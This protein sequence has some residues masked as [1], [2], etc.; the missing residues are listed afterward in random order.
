MSSHEGI[1]SSKPTRMRGHGRET[2][3]IVGIIAVLVGALVAII[4][5]P[6]PFLFY[7]TSVVAPIIFVNYRVGVW[8]LVFLLPFDQ[9]QLIPHDVLGITGFNPVNSL[10]MFTLLSLLVSFLAGREVIQLVHLPRPFLAYVGVI[11][12]G[13]YVGAGSVEHSI[14]IPDANTGV[15]TEPTVTRYI[16]DHF[17]KPMIILIV[18]W[19][20]AT[21][22]R[23]GNGRPL[24]WALAAAFVIFSL[25]IAHYFVING[26]ST[27]RPGHTR[28]FLYWTGMHANEIGL[29]A[30]LGVAI[31]LCAAGATRGALPRLILFACAAAAGMTAVLTFSRGAF[32]GLSLILGYYLLSLRRI[33]QFLLAFS[34]ILGAGSLLP[35]NALVERATTGFQGADTEVITAGRL[36]Y[37]WRPLLPTFW[38]APIIG[39]GLGSTAWASPNLRGEMLPVGHPH[40]AYLGVLLDLGLVGIAVVGAFFWSA[41]RT[42]RRLSQDHVDSQ[43][44]GVFEGGLVSLMC[45]AIQGLT[46]DQF[47]PTYSQVALW[48]CYGLALGHIQSMHSKER[49]SARSRTLVSRSPLGTRTTIT[50]V[51]TR[52]FAGSPN[53]PA[54]TALRPGPSPR[55]IRKASATARLRSPLDKSWGQRQQP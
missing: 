27:L 14:V 46:D 55:P 50:A 36:D 24:I 47:V 22:A 30:N 20:A 7:F 19:L 39:H 42:F 44:Q 34:I 4:G 17:A 31:L 12:F 21:V 43:W 49:C 8:L 3:I 51:R 13:V 35:D 54:L 2:A 38:E 15:I 11:A 52:G 48:V 53:K 26:V 10:L 45:L 6:I 37:I 23:N 28:E 9:T 5:G 33:G 18:A 29:Q 16:L 40:S 41:W 1:Y 32:I 25:A